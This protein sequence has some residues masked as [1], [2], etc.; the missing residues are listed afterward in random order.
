MFTPI[1]PWFGFVPGGLWWSADEAAFVDENVAED[2]RIVAQWA[3]LPC[4]VS[5]VAIN[6]HVLVGAS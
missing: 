6:D 5:W 1:V 3:Y 4:G 2:G